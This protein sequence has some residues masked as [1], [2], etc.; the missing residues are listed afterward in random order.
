MYI[1]T[2][3]DRYML[4]FKKK[5]CKV[6]RIPS[7]EAHVNA[8]I[9][10]RIMQRCPACIHEQ[11]GG[12]VGFLNRFSITVGASQACLACHTL[13]HVQHVDTRSSIS[14]GLGRWYLLCVKQHFLLQFVTQE[15]IQRAP[16]WKQWFFSA[17]WPCCTAKSAVGQTKGAC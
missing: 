11:V 5:Q 14:T 9:S 4:I 13:K 6:N 10:C 3:K 8:D 15:K 2:V 16:G 12:S 17:F 1:Q 7:K